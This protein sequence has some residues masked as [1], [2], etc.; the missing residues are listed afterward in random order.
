MKTVDPQLAEAIARIESSCCDSALR[1]EP[2]YSPSPAA[3]DALDKICTWSSATKHFA[4]A[5]SWGRYQIMGD[6]LYDTCGVTLD[7][8][9]YCADRVAQD[10][11]FYEFL[12]ADG[13]ETL[14]AAQ[15]ASSLALRVR[16]ARSYNGPG[17]VDAY[18]L[19][20]AQSLQA[21]GF[22]ITNS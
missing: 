9:A 5:S 22:A 14:T 3:F 15:L 13:L 10:A 18:A 4:L 2:A 17:N 11:A 6:N 1:F 16:F 8:I 21:L 12:K 20:I 19:S 7:P